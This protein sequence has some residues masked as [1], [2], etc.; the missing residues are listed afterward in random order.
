MAGL[1]ERARRA[2]QAELAAVA[3]E[4]FT[5]RGFDEVTVDDIARAAGVSKRSFFRYFPAKEDAVFGGVQVMGD[6]I[7]DQLTARP[8][9]EP[10]WE[11]LHAVLRDWVARIDAESRATLR[12][13][14]RTPSLRARFQQRREEARSRIAAALAAR[15]SLDP[16]TADLL[17]SAAGAA[18]DCASREWLRRGPDADPAHLLDTAFTHL[19]PACTTP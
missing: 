18:V 7:A 14:E 16:F 1:R 2:V 10:P 5:E 15:A 11:S 8:A 4:L 12:L 6:D 17:T 19:R 9:G 3:L 13:I